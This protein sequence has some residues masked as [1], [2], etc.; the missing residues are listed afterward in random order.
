MMSW[1][2]FLSTNVYKDCVNLAEF[3]AI[4][5]NDSKIILFIKLSSGMT[6]VDKLSENYLSVMT[7][8]TIDGPLCL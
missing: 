3:D 2:Y 7:L 4:V 1:L 6:E 8:L 5:C